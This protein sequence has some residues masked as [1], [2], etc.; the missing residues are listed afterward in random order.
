MAGHCFTTIYL[1]QGIAG[2][3]IL[4]KG[5]R[6]GKDMCMVFIKALHN[7]DGC[8]EGWGHAQ[9]DNHDLRDCLSKSPPD[10]RY[11]MYHW[12]RQIGTYCRQTADR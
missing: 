1:C 5:A 8:D 10:H 4:L 12:P 7:L 9:Y 11:R 3:C 2:D 6:F